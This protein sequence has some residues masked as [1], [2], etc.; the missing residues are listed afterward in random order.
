MINIETLIN[1]SECL[2]FSTNKM[3][4]NYNLINDK[5][6]L[7]AILNNIKNIS[8]NC[9]AIHKSFKSSVNINKLNNEINELHYLHN[10][11]IIEFSR[12]GSLMICSDNYFS[13]VPL[14]IDILKKYFLQFRLFLLELGS[15][16]R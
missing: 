1:D 5:R 13:V 10:N 12:N 15:V 3:F 7:I 8:I 14:N 2:M 9:L 4:N 16:L 11:S 6:I